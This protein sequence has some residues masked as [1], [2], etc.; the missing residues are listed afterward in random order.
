MHSTRKR[1]SRINEESLK[2]LVI[3]FGPRAAAREANL[4]VNTVLSLARRR[5]WKR[6]NASQPASSQIPSM[7]AATSAICETKPDSTQVSICTRSPADS[8]GLALAGLRS[9]STH[10]L[11][12]YVEKASRVAAESDSPLQISRKVK[13]V[14][15]VHKALWPNE[16]QRNDILQIGVLVGVVPNPGRSVSA[17]DELTR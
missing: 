5:G 10:H 6:N 15:D 13:D 8:L 3:A 12:T 17:P 11:A 7:P 14:S 9:R 2:T 4:N 1:D 16:H